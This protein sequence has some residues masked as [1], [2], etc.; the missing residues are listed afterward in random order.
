VCACSNARIQAQ[1][2]KLEKMMSIGSRAI[3]ATQ[4]RID[5]DNRRI[6]QVRRA[7][8]TRAQLTRPSLN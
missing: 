7:Q 1:A 4:G 5:D 3:Q 2:D 8:L 6:S